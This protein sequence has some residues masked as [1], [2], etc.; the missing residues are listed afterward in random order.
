VP[1]LRL[2]GGSRRRLSGRPAGR[3]PAVLGRAGAFSDTV[4]LASTRLVNDYAALA[5]AAP[6]IEPGDAEVIGEDLPGKPE[7]TIAILGAGTGFGV[8][9][10]VRRSGRETVLTTEGG[11]ISLAPVDQLDIE[12]WRVLGARFGRV[13]VERILS[14]PG[15]LNLYQA[16]ASIEGMAADAAT[17]GEVTRRAASGDPI[18]ERTIER[19]CATLGS[20]A[21]DFALSYGAQ[22]GVYIAGG[23]S[24][25]LMQTLR[26]GEFRARF[27]QKGRFES[28]LAQIPTRVILHPH[29]IAL[30]GAARELHRV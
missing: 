20:V 16:L 22:G 12:I 10:L 23:V 6:I 27:E 2:G 8:S 1:R 21:G 5:L 11:H 26:S 19:F 28:Y 29:T 7:G 15:L 9:A 24:K 18:A 17:P 14:G 30:L 13:S 4:K 3:G 25:Y